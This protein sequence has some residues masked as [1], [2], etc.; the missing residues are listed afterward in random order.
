MKSFRSLL[1]AA[2]LVTA[3]IFSIPAQAINI[4]QTLMGQWSEISPGPGESRRGINLQ[5]FKIGPELGTVFAIAFIY[6]NAGNQVWITGNDPQVRPGE[7]TLEFNMN[8]I[9]GGLP[10]GA[11]AG[12]PTTSPAGT[13]SMEIDSCNG[14]T[15]TLNSADLGNATFAMDRGESIGLTFGPGR[16]AYQAEFTG[17]PAFSDGEG[18]A[19][20]S[21]ILSGALEGDI[22]FTNDTTWILNGPVF[23]GDDIDLG[24]STGNLFIEPGT[25][26]V[27]A[28][29]NDF[30]G[31][32]R[33]SKIFAEGTSF[34][35][36]VMTGPI[37][38][39]DPAADA[40]TWGGLVINGR[41]PINICTSGVCEQDGEGGSGKFGGNDP[42]DSSG[43]LR[44]VRIQFAGFKIND[45][46]ELNGIAFQG[47]GR[48]TVIEYI[49]VHDNADDGIEFFGGTANAKYLLLTDIEDDSLDWTDG[50]NGNV[51]YV[52]VKQNDDALTETERGIEADNF[53]DN[54]DALPRSRPRISHV[55]FIGNNNATDTTTGLLFRRGT[56]VNISNAIVTGFDKC[57]DLDS[58]ATFTAAG[59]PGSLTGTLTIQ[60]SMLNCDTNF[61]EEDGDAFS[62]QAF[63]EGQNGNS[64]GNPN[65]SGIFPA[66][67]APFL[68]GFPLNR[69]IFPD[70][71]DGA[72]YKG[73]FSSEATAWTHGWTEFLD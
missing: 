58:S 9:T 34:A 70:F 27:G 56:G 59:A 21:C 57:L 64:V 44:F 18:L 26:I 19:P 5:Y 35:P 10:L 60:N 6:D 48:N 36:I 71:F 13:L 51:Q 23:I 28:A 3:G 55:T 66:D 42:D 2:G 45:E 32:Q 41:A 46:D 53:E 11:A 30:L 15:A 16:C 38:S 61:E 8:F 22:H 1:V 63:Y 62:V 49:Q 40:G 31:I 24:G 54:N 12:S 47:V 50:W 43:V 39:D 69:A 25:R 52:V 65:L 67:G 68:S 17:C 33:G 20:R 37:N 73:A 4:D 29:G 14:A 72:D 7:T